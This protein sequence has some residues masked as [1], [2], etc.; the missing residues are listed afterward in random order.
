MVSNAFRPGLAME[1]WLW[2]ASYLDS[3]TDLVRAEITGAAIGFAPL[4]HKHVL[5]RDGLSV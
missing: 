5:F 1:D 3:Q 4:P 2:V